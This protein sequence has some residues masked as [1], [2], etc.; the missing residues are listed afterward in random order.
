MAGVFL[1][2][3]VLGLILVLGR[4]ARAAPVV[5]EGVVFE[6]GIEYANPDG[7][8][9]RL[10]L[11]RPKKGDGPFPAV[12]CIHGGGFRAGKRESYDGLCLRLAQHGYV[13]LT[14]SYRLA[15][16]YPFPAAVH[17]VKAAVRWARANAARYKIDPRRIGVTGGSAGG[18]LAQFLGVT[19]GVKEF[20]G[21]G[22]NAGRSSRVAC[23]V[24]FYG[25]SDFTHSYGKSVDAAQV[26]PLFLGGDLKTARRQ[27]IRASPLYWVTPD[28]APTLCIHG[29]EDKYVAHEQAVWLTDRLKAAG[30]EAELLTLKGAGHGFRGKD[31]ETA[32]RA[33]LAFFDSQLKGRKSASG[34]VPFIYVAD[35]ETGKVIKIKPDG[36][37]V[38]DAPNGNSHDVQVL[39]NRNVL[40]VHGSAVEEVAPDRKVVWR[41]GRPTIVAAESAQ[42]LPNGNTVIADNGR[43]KVI[44]V[45]RAGKIVWEFAV[46]ND[47]RRKT[48][49]MRQVRR[50]ANGNTLIC[51][52]TEDKV[53][54]VAP[55]KKVIWSY[56]V[57][58]PYL[59]TRL[60][61]G[62]TLISSGDGYGSPRGFFVVEVDRTG[63]VVWK[64]GG[65]DAPAEQQLRWP[66]GHVRLANGNTLI[67]EARGGVLREVSPD[68]KT[69]RVIRSFAMRDP[70]TI[71]IADE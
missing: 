67:A 19:A 40:I 36:T 42:R 54:E 52:S 34:A 26:L 47:N 16:K 64:Y 33:M 70:A 17:D 27:H 51:A 8:Q 30:V 49:T 20:E 23:V 53:L 56:E 3:L 57:P 2:S 46:P 50:L 58:F 69:V 44:E 28:A 5:P 68:K 63:K 37:L 12:L 61:N 32:E 31:A 13:A 21:L 55:D 39:P 7:Q 18:H 45:D 71:A 22:G 6:A 11:A 15:P 1:R 29:T 41:V 48:P 4:S 60:A 25:P 62:H 43:R 38:W 65:A 10:N 66:S 24:N 9:L 35:H 59:A 14:V